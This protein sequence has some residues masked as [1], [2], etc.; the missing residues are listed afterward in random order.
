MKKDSD[1][2]ADEDL[3]Y[4]VSSM[5]GWRISMEDAHTTILN[6]DTDKQ[7]PKAGKLSYF[8]VYDGHGGD[9]VAK[10]SGVNVHKI[11][12]QQ[13]AFADE[14]FSK[15]LKDTFLSTDKAILQGESKSL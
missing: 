2:G 11:L 15:A 7:K 14:E 12:L 9:K 10:F 6:L 1:S 8:A 3:I 5:Q 4:G 13:A